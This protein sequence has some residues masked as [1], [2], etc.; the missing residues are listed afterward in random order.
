VVRSLHRVYGSIHSLPELVTLSPDAN[1]FLLLS[2]RSLS[3][4][5][6]L[7]TVDAAFLVRYASE[8]YL[9]SYEPVERDSADAD[10]VYEMVNNLRLELMPLTT[11]V[12]VLTHIYG[13]VYK[14]PFIPG[15][16]LV[17]AESK[18][19][20]LI[21]NGNATL[22][23]TAVPINYIDQVENIAYSF[24]GNVTGASLVLY[25]HYAGVDYIIDHVPAITSGGWHFLKNKLTLDYAS[26]LLLQVLA[27]H[28]GDI[29][30][31]KYTGMRCELLTP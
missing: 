18:S 26:Y 23:T 29:L 11:S 9:G 5:N 25:A 30:S 14:Q 24:T 22:A 21:G 20:T 17:Q 4:L 28:T 15:Y 6:D 16:S 2:D 1:Q 7:A 19:L 12:P 10:K 27:G 3:L 8:M 31:L 13:T